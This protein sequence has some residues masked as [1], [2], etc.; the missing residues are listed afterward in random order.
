MDVN[1]RIR[2]QIREE[3]N[4]QGVTQAELARRLGIK[5]PSLAQVLSGKR[6]TMPDS[7][8]DVLDAL[9]L[10]LVAVPRKEG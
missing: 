5:P 4:R 10:E 1:A 7:L 9:G 6:G 8:M 3:M 2:V